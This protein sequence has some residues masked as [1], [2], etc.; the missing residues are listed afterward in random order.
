[1]NELFRYWAIPASLCL[2][3][4]LAML[5]LPA[6]SAPYR[7]DWVTLVALY[8]VLALPRSFGVGFSW[9]SGLLLDVVQGALLGQHALGLAIVSY[10]ARRFHQRIRVYPLAQQGLIVL[11]L[12]MVKQSVVL[13]ISGIIGHAPDNLLV[14]FAPSFI[15][16]LLW[17]WIF[18]VLRDVRRRYQVA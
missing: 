11:V 2:A 7:P 12:L 14:Y 1:M 18:V 6:W 17:P 8:W 15:G 16:M 10:V 13:W 5:P 3:L 4:M 9:C